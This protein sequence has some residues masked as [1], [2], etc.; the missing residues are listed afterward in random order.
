LSIEFAW[1]L[2]WGWFVVTVLAVLAYIMMM[3]RG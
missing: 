1:F 3:R 2:T